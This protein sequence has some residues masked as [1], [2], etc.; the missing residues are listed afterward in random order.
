V[1]IN[2][3]DALMSGVFERVLTTS[4]FDFVLLGLLATGKALKDSKLLFSVDA[5]RFGGVL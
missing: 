1:D 3:D 5:K 2:D 4:N